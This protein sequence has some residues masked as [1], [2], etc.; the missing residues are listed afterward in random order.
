MGTWRW[1]YNRVV[2]LMKTAYE[3]RGENLGYIKMRKVWYAEMV[4]GNEWIKA[5]PPNIVYEAMRK[6]NHDYVQILKLRKRGTKYNLPRCRRG[7]RGSFSLLKNVIN[8]R[9]FYTQRLGGMKFSEKL[10]EEVRESRVV[11]EYGR[12]YLSMP[13]SVRRC[14]AERVENQDRIAA[15]DPGVRTF[16][17]IF[18]TDGIGKIGHGSFQR[19]V[20]LA[21]VLDKLLSEMTK[22]KAAKRHRMKRAAG[23]LRRRIRNLVED[24]HYQS[25]GW[26]FGKFDTLIIPE[27]DFTTAV[28]RITQRIR[29]KS[30][31][32]LL[33]WA[34]GLFRRRAAHVAERLGKKV[35]TVNE[36]YTSKTAN[37]T[38]EI[39]HNLGGGKA[40]ASGGL[41][42]DRDVNG[43]LGIF[44][45]ALMGNPSL[46][47]AA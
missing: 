25:L 37:W 23:N 42:F 47:R 13:V 18:S 3:E 40:I 35:F 10:P 43:A 41:R 28:R 19:I 9:G 8:E 5:I 15:L 31:R 34:F 2:T 30:V 45:K 22:V 17:T 39:V 14:V 4:A 16:A 1:V 29:R 26:L 32:S 33:T 12:W 38:G 20:R 44:L 46:Q 6:A 21:H 7:T 11:Y 27:C 36:A 24:M